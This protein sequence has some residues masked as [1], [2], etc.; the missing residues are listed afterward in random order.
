MSLIKLSV[1]QSH[2]N[3]VPTALLICDALVIRN[4]LSPPQKLAPNEN[5]V[6]QNVGLHKEIFTKGFHGLHTLRTGGVLSRRVRQQP[7]GGF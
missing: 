3:E 4:S 2:V 5:I 1:S 6:R 7:H